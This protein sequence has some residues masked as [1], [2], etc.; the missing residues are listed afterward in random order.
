MKFIYKY[1]DITPFKWIGMLAVILS[2]LFT[3]C[4]GNIKHDNKESEIREDN[5]N[6]S[7]DPEN[8]TDQNNANSE[9][10]EMEIDTSS[11]ASFGGTEKSTGMVDTDTSKKASSGSNK[12]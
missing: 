3:S 2:L 6:T 7:F 10:T 12:Q 11:S 9:Q 1:I 4:E 5:A 8:E